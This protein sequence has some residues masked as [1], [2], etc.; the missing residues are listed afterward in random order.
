MQARF[1]GQ[2]GIALPASFLTSHGESLNSSYLLNS[3][4]C[5][6]EIKTQR[7]IE[8]CFVTKSPEILFAYQSRLATADRKKGVD[9]FHEQLTT[10][11]G[12]LNSAFSAVRLFPDVDGIHL[13][14]QTLGTRS[15]RHLLP[16]Y[17]VQNYA[18]QIVRI[19]NNQKLSLVFDGDGVLHPPLK[20]TLNADVVAHWLGSTPSVAEVAK[21]ADWCNPSSLGFVSHRGK[22][23]RVPLLHIK[24]IKPF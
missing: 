18:A 13:S 10:S 16:Y 4:L 6:A 8:Y 17:A 9:R 21:W 12:E 1:L 22:F 14:K 23:E 5:V 3:C 7:G 2:E 24:D 20:T 11:Y 19:L 15:S